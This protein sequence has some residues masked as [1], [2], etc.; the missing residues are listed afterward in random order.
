MKKKAGDDLILASRFP[1]I[2]DW[3]DESSGI[4]KMHP[5][6]IDLPDDIYAK[7]LLIINSHMSCCDNDLARQ[8][9]SDD[10]V[11]FIL[12]AKTPGGV[13]DLDEGT[14]FVLCGDLNL[15]GIVTTIKDNINWRD[16]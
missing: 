6:L 15:V 8:E 16:N 13:I 10:F 3:P 2:Q 11:N 12:D 4:K 9:Q 1:I 5:C 7:D 14:P